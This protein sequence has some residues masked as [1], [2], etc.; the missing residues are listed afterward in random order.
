MPAELLPHHVMIFITLMGLKWPVGLCGPLTPRPAQKE[1]QCLE[2]EAPRGIELTR[3]ELSS[4]Q[5]QLHG[6]D[7]GGPDRLPPLT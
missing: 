2:A 3:K 5:G 4:D 7:Q 6:Q 1:V